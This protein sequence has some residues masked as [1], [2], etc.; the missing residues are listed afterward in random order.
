MFMVNIGSESRTPFDMFRG[1]DMVQIIDKT[2]QQE[3]QRYA[4]RHALTTLLKFGNTSR[5]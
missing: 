2:K 5:V 1:R 4:T 3:E